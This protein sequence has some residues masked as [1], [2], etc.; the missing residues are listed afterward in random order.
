[1]KL[2][3]DIPKEYHELYKSAWEHLDHLHWAHDFNFTK[4]LAIA[5]GVPLFGVP[6]NPT[7]GELI[8]ALFGMSCEDFKHKWGGGEITEEWWNSLYQEVEHE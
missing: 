6:E 2:I 8:K 4:E 1:M 3:I 7:N 5:N